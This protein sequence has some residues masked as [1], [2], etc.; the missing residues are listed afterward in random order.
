MKFFNKY[1]F[2]ILFGILILALYFALRFYHIL[3]LP[4]FTDEAIYIR[5]SQIAK[6]DASWRFISLTD[7][8][9]P[10]YVWV[11]MILLRLIHD[12]LL[13]GRMVSVLAGFGTTIGL[14]FLGKELFKNRWIGLL[15]SFLYVVY[16][17]ALVYDRMALYDSLVTMFAV[18]GWYLTILLVRKIRSYL[19]FVLGLVMGGGFLTKSSDFFIAALLP[20]SLLLFD[21]KQKQWQKKLLQWTGFAI[22]SVALAFLYYAVLRLS[23]FYT[24]ISEKNALFVY[25]FKDWLQHPF[26]YLPDNLRG[27]VDWFLT[28]MK[29][30]VLLLIVGSFFFIKDFIK[31]KILV[32]FW[33]LVPFSY[34]AFFGKTLYPRFIFFMT[35]A[36]LP[37]AAY[38]LYKIINMSSKKISLYLS[39]PLLFV[40]FLGLSVYAD[41]GIL[42]DFAHAQIPRIDTDQYVNS[43]PA[44]NG[45]KQAVAFFKEKAKNEKIYIATEGTFGLMPYSLEIYLVDNPNITIHGIWPIS[46]TLPQ[47]LETISKKIP[48]YVIFYQPCPSC[49]IPGE[50]PIGWHLVH[51]ANYQQGRGNSYL[52]IYQVIQ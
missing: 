28:Y 27:I 9:Q 45:V 24:I 44:G 21:F 25:P 43:W 49:G 37:L 41:Y 5:W 35:V 17:F 48:T 3:N 30:P 32:V 19:P 42:T 22:L 31:E 46:D 20:A 11:A 13:A 51:L 29:I 23:P 40:V 4:I 39:I 12:P 15:S 18:W 47:Q 10:M 33:F 38:T 34:L 52:S 2:E 26:T 1:K 36:L 7:G 14:F 8:K 16:P 6:Q 50:A